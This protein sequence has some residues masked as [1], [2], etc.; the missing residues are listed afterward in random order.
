MFT[1]HD[2]SLIILWHDGQGWRTATKGSLDSGRARKAL[3]R[4]IRPTGNVL[5]GFIRDEPGHGGG[6]RLV[7]AG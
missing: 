4:A 7:S 5:E 3:F 2:G 1:K 6:D